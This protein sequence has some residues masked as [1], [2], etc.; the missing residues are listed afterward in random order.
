M[1]QNVYN[2][3]NRALQRNDFDL[4]RELLLTSTAEQPGDLVQLNLLVS[5]ARRSKRVDARKMVRR[6]NEYFRKTKKPLIGAAKGWQYASI[7]DK[8]FLA[9]RQLPD[10]EHRHR[11][12]ESMPA[13][14]VEPRSAADILNHVATL[15]T[16]QSAL[17]YLRNLSSHRSSL[18]NEDDFRGEKDQ[19]IQ[20]FL[21]ASD[22]QS[23]SIAIIGAGP[24]GLLL[25]HALTLNLARKV[26]VLVIENRIHEQGWKKEYNRD[27]LTHILKSHF[28]GIVDERILTVFNCIGAGEYIGAPLNIAENLLFLG[29]RSS[30]VRF[31][32]RDDINV[33]N[34]GARHFDCIF[35]TTGGRIQWEEINEFHY[36][37]DN[38]PGTLRLKLPATDNYGAGFKHFGITNSDP[39]GELI[40]ELNRK[41]QYLYPSIGGAEIRVPMIKITRVPLDAAEGILNIVKGMNGDSK[42][43]VWPGK[44]KPEVNE[45]L[46]LINVSWDVHRFLS[47]RISTSSKLSIVGPALL[48][49][50]EGKDHRLF[51]LLTNILDSTKSACNIEAPF[52]YEPRLRSNLAGEADLNGTPLYWVG[53]S[54]FNG[55]PKAGNGLST[56]LE[57]VRNLHDI[58]VASVQG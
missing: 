41:Q 24:I 46:I 31:M 16:P 26:E 48:D 15:N 6:L 18:M 39:T 11:D 28:F 5:L 44:L 38:E 47:N 53:D 50:L 51:L 40:V 23:S 10:S 54:L 30:G 25:A 14:S 20:S 34:L 55:H 22:E 32:F 52:V 33:N 29:A 7:L 56:N 57:I 8:D 2:S 1:S 36:K 35:D 13:L 45:A 42:F 27:W 43:Y 58:I 12:I 3:L 9:E 21:E 37:T 19:I 4:A 17:N 49:Q